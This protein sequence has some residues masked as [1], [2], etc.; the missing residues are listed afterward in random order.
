[1]NN[2]PIDWRLTPGFML[3]SHPSG[4]MAH[5]F[6]GHFLSSKRARCPFLEKPIIQPGDRFDWG[7]S[8]PLEKV[9]HSRADLDR[10]LINPSLLKNSIAIIEPWQNVGINDRGEAVR[11]SLNV[12]YIAQRIADMDSVLYPVW[13]SGVFDQERLASTISSAAAYVVEGGDPSTYDPSTWTSPVCSQ[14]DMFSLVESLILSRHPMSAAGIFI[15]VGH[16]LAAEAHIRLIRRAVTEIER[17]DR[18]PIDPDQFVLNAL[19]ITAA[20]IRAT[21]ESLNIIKHDGRVAASNWNAPEFSVT[22]NEDKECGIRRLLPYESPKGK[23]GSIP[24]ELIQAHAV[25]ADEHD[26]VIDTNI[27]YESELHIAMFHSDEV[28]EEAILFANWAYQML[29]DAILPDRSLVAASP[30]HWLIQLPDSVEILAST[31][32]ENGDI[33]TECAATCINYKDYETKT[34]RRSFTCQFHPELFEDLR[35]IGLTDPPSYQSLNRDDGVRLF[36]RLL[37]AALGE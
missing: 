32:D 10:L 34:I 31:A 1:M 14:T 37:H 29:H 7:Q 26:G 17:L 23:S 13:S 16:Q 3:P 8:H 20:H 18:L 30:L 4:E 21:G 35:A 27:A 25:S 19:K 33:M 36:V 5:V 11:A 15:C 28:N 22:R 24:W 9:I 2:P 12:A 6:L